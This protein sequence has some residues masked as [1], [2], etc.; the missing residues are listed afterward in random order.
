MIIF[1]E[2]EFIKNYD[3]LRSS[4]KIAEL[5]GCDKTTILNYA[6]KI[7]YNVKNN[8]EIKIVNVP[9]EDVYNLYL[10]LGSCKKVAEKY[11]CSS[12]AIMNYLKKEGYTLEN[13][14]NKL[15]K[16]SEDEFIKS[17]NELKSAEKMGEKYNCSSTAILN[18]AKKI[19]YDVNSN[20]NYKLTKEQKEE[21]I[22]SYNSKTSNELSKIYNVSRGMITKLW[23]DAGLS[24]KE[25][26]NS[27]TT[28]KDITGQKFGL[29]TVMY[30]TNKRNSAGIIY[31]HCKCKCGVEKDVLGNSLR[32]GLSLSCGAHSNISKG[33]EK[34]KS[35]LFEANIPFEIEKKFETCKD[36]KELPFDFYVD[37][38]YLIEFDGIQHF[39]ENSIFNYE[40]THEHDIIKTKWCKENNIPLIRIPYTHL[41]DLCLEDLLLET[42]TF[43]E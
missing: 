40:Y 16:I 4:R 35:I 17:Y 38:K 21:I 41:K 32:N 8:K 37:N 34:I 9:V 26:L 22:K 24:G 1:E 30:K 33:N 15:Q 12:T 11:H 18:Y 23:Y 3:I 13:K 27:V 14:N 5:Y 2:T 29:W 36:K 19:H 7:N 25:V 42:S 43:I 20:K 28:E 6:K 10:E 31:W 39:D